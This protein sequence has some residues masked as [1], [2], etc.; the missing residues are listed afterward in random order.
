M[1][2]AHSHKIESNKQKRKF[3]RGK[4]IVE[5]KKEEVDL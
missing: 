5:I 4:V 3:H 2:D 1:W